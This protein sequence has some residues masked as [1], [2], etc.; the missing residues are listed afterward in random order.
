M[1]TGFHN[2]LKEQQDAVFF[3]SLVGENPWIAVFWS[4]WR[5]LGSNAAHLAFGVEPPYF[6]PFPPHPE[7]ARWMA[8]WQSDTKESFREPTDPAAGG[9]PE[10]CF[11]ASVSNAGWG[12]KGKKYG[13]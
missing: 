13:W 9:E 6:F 8:H 10:D 2:L 5:V 11:V 12:G 3:K 7:K 1:S 4:V